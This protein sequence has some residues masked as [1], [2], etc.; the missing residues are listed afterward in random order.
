MMNGKKPHFLEIFL[1]NLSSQRLEVPSKFIKHLGG[2]TSGSLS[3]TGPSGN[4]WNVDLIGDNGHLFFDGGWPTF[5]RDHSIQCGDSLVFRYDG[6][7]HFTVQIF[8][9][10]S[11]EKDE[12]LN[13][14]CSQGSNDCSG[15]SGKKRGRGKKA[16]VID[17]GN[18]KKHKLTLIPVH[19]DLPSSSKE[20]DL[21]IC[22]IENE[23]ASSTM[24]SDAFREPL[25]VALPCISNI[26]WKTPKNK[27]AK[28]MQNTSIN[29]SLSEFI[30]SRAAQ[31]I[32]SSSPYFVRVMNYSNISGNG[33]MKLPVKFSSVHLP[34]YK[35]K[36]TL[37]NLNGDDWL[38]NCLPTVKKT[39]T[40]HTF[41]GGWLAFV[42][43]NGIKIEDVCIFELVGELEML[44]RILRL[45]VEGLE[46]PTGNSSFDACN[47]ELSGWPLEADTIVTEDT[48]GDQFLKDLEQLDD[49]YLNDYEDHEANI[50][51]MASIQQKATD[52]FAVSDGTTVQ[53]SPSGSVPLPL[54]TTCE[55]CTDEF[56]LST[57]EGTILNE[58]SGHNEVN[59]KARDTR[60]KQATIEE[61]TSHLTFNSPFPSFMKVIV[62]SNVSHSHTV[63]VPRKFSAA[64]LPSYKTNIVLRN[65]EGQSWRVVS[66]CYG[67]Q[68]KLCGGWMSFA[69]KNGVK[70]GDVCIFE[71]VDEKVLQVRVFKSGHKE[72]ICQSKDVAE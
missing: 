19:L 5:V 16:P 49:L 72:K 32:T 66:A 37:K 2:R 15:S 62:N 69:R 7:S 11:C 30:E 38:I 68:T 1:P 28:K 33:T 44:V 18:E 17:V 23:Y 40:V 8:D 51:T 47:I 67:N 25:V 34:N 59:S 50:E 29:T 70:V 48:S 6:N 57:A 22:S 20:K 43:A 64:H 12:A 4:S 46:N 41:C 71:L 54:S 10:S 31:Y 24:D 14:R 13:A 9:E 55:E 45:G 3:L 52:I 56:L 36:V 63:D 35:T 39:S 21:E 65:M 60:N 42:R 26:D 53:R 61:S 58:A 27:A